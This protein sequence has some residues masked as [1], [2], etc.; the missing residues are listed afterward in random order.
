MYVGVAVRPS[1]A[2]ARIRE[3]WIQVAYHG[4]VH[5]M[6]CIR[7]FLHRTQGMAVLA[8]VTTHDAHFGRRVH[9]SAHTRPG[10]Q[11][12]TAYLAIPSYL[13]ETPIHHPTDFGAIDSSFYLCHVLPLHES[14]RGHVILE[15][16][17]R[18]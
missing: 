5:W 9:C 16:T 17:S 12:C 3:A 7:L 15:A 14:D 13:E 8:P 4:R 18:R 6:D 1:R 10:S 2:T 11:A